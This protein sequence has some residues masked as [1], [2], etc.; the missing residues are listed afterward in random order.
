M[1]KRQQHS[2]L[3]GAAI[4]VIATALSKIIGAV[5]K[6]PLNNIIGDLGF[7][8]YSSAYDLFVPI[9]GI[10][11]TGLPMVVSRMVAER[12]AE[13]RYLSAK[14]VFKVSVIAFTAFGAGMTALMFLLIK[15]FLALTDMTGATYYSLLAVA[16]AWLFC[17][18]M[19]AYT[20]YYEGHGNM[21]PTAWANVIEALSKLV[22]GYTFAY[23]A[24]KKSANV[25]HAAAAAIL[26]VTIGVFLATLFTFIYYKVKG[27]NAKQITNENV[28]PKREILKSIALLAVPIV[29][30]SFVTNMTTFIDLITVKW[31]LGNLMGE[32][33]EHIKAMYGA[34]IDEYN[35]TAHE[36]LTVENM[37]TF[38]YGVRS[39]T[40]TI[41]N[42]VPS[43][44]SV[45]GI[46][47]LPSL[48]H[49]W[50]KEDH[51]QDEVKNCINSVLKV[52]SIITFPAAIGMIAVAPNIMSLLYESHASVEIGAP[53]LRIYGV[54][55]IF[56]G[57][58]VPLVNMLQAVG[59]PYL[60]VRNM[61]IGAALK[62]ALNIG[63]VAVP[64]I[65]V[66][67]A[68][69]GTLGCFLCIFV[70]NFYSL[71][72]ITGVKPEVWGTLIKPLF[73]A[74]ICG[75]AALLCSTLLGLGTLKTLLSIAV[76]AV[77][78]FVLLFAFSVLKIEDVLKSPILNKPK[79]CKNSH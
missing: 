41:Y 16:P 75:A 10:S 24:V 79:S 31:Q 2:F 48:V 12:V 44:V 3:E 26:G 56:S 47:A 25:A 35:A 9:Y 55:A 42:L 64:N 28:E 50:C 59:K 69:Y 11:L 34:S 38:L 57:L 21:Y 78:Y 40:N 52:T 7:G 15:P 71:Y 19:S 43:I 13:G 22:F 60:P 46:S 14:R 51:K 61:L 27:D 20:G 33:F 49:V 23:V 4:L 29:L 63:L 6:I 66:H 76:A 54:A 37:P 30:S 18:V 36:L 72:K 73:A 77:I 67:G 62:A 65:N 1:S 32:S 8:Y 74:L 45:L 39:K 70:L 53:L 58:S 5:F 17:C 68:A